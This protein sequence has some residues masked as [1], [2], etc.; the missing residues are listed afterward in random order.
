M[1]Y[2]EPCSVSDCQRPATHLVRSRVYD[3]EIARGCEAHMR[4]VAAGGGEIVEDLPVP[5]VQAAAFTVDGLE[6][7]LG[8][9]RNVCVAV[10]DLGERLMRATDAQRAA[11][12]ISVGGYGLWWE[13]VDEDLS[14]AGLLR[15]AHRRIS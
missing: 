6:L 4:D 9:G 8:D 12:K 2:G 11:V 7:E 14:I 15:G 5:R 1:R 3:A 13:Q 10:A